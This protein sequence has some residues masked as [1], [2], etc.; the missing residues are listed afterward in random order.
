VPPPVTTTPSLSLLCTLQDGESVSRGWLGA[1][2]GWFSS[3]AMVLFRGDPSGSVFCVGLPGKGSRQ[4][5]ERGWIP[6][7]PTTPQTTT[8]LALPPLTL[9]IFPVC[10][11][12][13]ET[14][15]QHA[16]PLPPPDPTCTH[17]M[18]ESGSELLGTRHPAPPSLF[19]Q[20]PPLVNNYFA[21]WGV[22]PAPLSLSLSPPPPPT[23]QNVETGGLSNTAPHRGF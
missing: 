7:I 22:L 20:L 2:L 15:A 13:V 17:T 5:R 3:G 8:T 11:P 12:G 14:G 21:H 6:L 16:S 9:S 19:S 1:S 10:A 23:R 4:C 18:G